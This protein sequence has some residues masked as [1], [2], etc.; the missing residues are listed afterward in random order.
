[1]AGV[2]H[3]AGTLDDSLISG[4]TPEKFATVFGPKVRGGWNVHLATRGDP[5][6]H[7]VLFSSVSSVFGSTGQANHAAANAF[8]DG[9]AG[10][11][12]KLG[13]PALAI[14]WGP[15]S[16]IGAAAARD[17]ASRG[18]LSGIGMIS[19]GEGIAILGAPSAA[20]APSGW[21][22]TECRPAAGAMARTV[23]L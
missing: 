17:V 20:V 22:A 14:D 15:W 12:Q 23:V 11:R 10:C 4:Q 18:D 6:E 9:L 8:L 7:F 1:M 16:D 13:L 19:P 21:A 3:L 5:L 2:F